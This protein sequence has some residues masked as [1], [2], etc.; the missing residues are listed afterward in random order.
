MKPWIERSVGVEV[1]DWVQYGNFE[2]AWSSEDPTGNPPFDYDFWTGIQWTQTAVQSISGTTVTFE[3]MIHFKNGTEQSSIYDIDVVTGEGFPFYFISAWLSAGYATYAGG[4]GYWPGPKI[5]ET[6]SRAYLGAL[7]E[8]NHFG[9]T[10]FY[11]DYF[12]RKNFRES[13]DVFWDRNTGVQTEYSYQQSFETGTEAYLTTLLTSFRI[14]DTNLWKNPW[15]CDINCDQKVDVRDIA[16]AALAFG[17]NVGYSRW[18]PRADINGD[19]IIDIRDLVIIA[20]N[21]G[22]IHQ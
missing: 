13:Y 7:R 22:T 14:V 18:D 1:G 3:F 5:N 20:K 17:S 6:I 21:F 9:V 11:E 4:V 2:V 8:T 16:M 12:G 19:G 15:P 10:R